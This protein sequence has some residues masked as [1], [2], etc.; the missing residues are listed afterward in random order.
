LNQTTTEK[1][2]TTLVNKSLIAAQVE[3]ATTASF[4]ILLEDEGFKNVLRR[5]ITQGS[6]VTEIV[7]ALVKYANEKL[8]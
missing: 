6:T 4:S 5:K 1:E 7:R 3:A 2:M 8:I